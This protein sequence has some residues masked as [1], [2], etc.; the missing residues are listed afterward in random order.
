MRKGF[1][2]PA[3]LF[4]E[5]CSRLIEGVLVTIRDKTGHLG[6]TGPILRYW[7]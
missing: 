6:Y 1:F 4:R 7:K 5:L 2:D 3:A